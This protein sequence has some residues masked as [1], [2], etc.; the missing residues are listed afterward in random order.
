[1]SD[2]AL[3]TL[4][5][6]HILDYIL[7]ARGNKV[8]TMQQSS[9]KNETYFVKR[10]SWMINVQP[11][12]IHCSFEDEVFNVCPCHS[13]ALCCLNDYEDKTELNNVLVQPKKDLKLAKRFLSLKG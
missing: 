7:K 13:N 4:H 6:V 11:V 9:F 8:K 1:M 2:S 12:F 3:E 5:K 10:P